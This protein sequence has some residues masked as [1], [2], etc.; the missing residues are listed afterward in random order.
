MTRPLIAVFF[1]SR[2]RRLPRLPEP[3]A[4]HL[5]GRAAHSE[6]EDARE[7]V[8][9]AIY[10]AGEVPQIVE[11]SPGLIGVATTPTAYRVWADPV[12]G[13]VTIDAVTRG[14]PDDELRAQIEEILRDRVAV[15]VEEV[16][17]GLKEEVTGHP[18]R[19]SL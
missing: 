8:A 6:V 15:C 3:A 10:A 7:C 14:H 2:N 4:R 9:S 19:R 11:D 18:A 17:P 1:C 12:T 13:E 16:H 5:V